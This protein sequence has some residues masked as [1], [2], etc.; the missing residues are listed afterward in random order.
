MT[1]P[2][3]SCKEL[4][5]IVTDYL[6]GVLPP[7][8]RQRFDAHLAE[9]DGCHTYLAQMQDTIRVTGAL[10]EE[11]L[12]PEATELLLAAFREWKSA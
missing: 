5:E 6:E 8:E 11:H 3:L 9:C 12:E 7:R 1:D 4:V 10:R 2:G